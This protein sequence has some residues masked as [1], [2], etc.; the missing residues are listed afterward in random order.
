[1]P[2]VPSAFRV[3]KHRVAAT[4]T[5]ANGDVARGWFFVGDSPHHPGAERVGELLNAEAGFLP[6]ERTDGGAS[7]TIL[8]NRPNLVTVA[9]ADLE[10]Q[11][12]SGYDLAT[13]RLVSMLLSTNQRLSGSVHVY[14]P[15]GR[16]RLSDWA[17]DTA[18]FRYV[19][20]PT[21][22]VLVNVG[23]ILEIT[24]LEEA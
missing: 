14:R 6:F 12:V 2:Q 7:G 20:T 13:R 23:H 10:A 8:Y 9:L 19:E 15:Q 4:V 16:D 11:R 24:E 5:L 3:A 21:E 18:L 22:T 1:M 17:R